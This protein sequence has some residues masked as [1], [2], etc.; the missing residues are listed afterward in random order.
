MR[1][2][3]PVPNHA[4]TIFASPQTQGITVTSPSNFIS[5]V[6]GNITAFISSVTQTAPSAVIF[7]VTDISATPA[8]RR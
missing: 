5:D 6:S 1:N 4:V 7:S 8:T 3:Q 2:N